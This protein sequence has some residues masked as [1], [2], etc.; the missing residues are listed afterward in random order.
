MSSTG[1]TTS[2]SHDFSAGGSTT[3]TGRE[4]PRNRA[5]SSIGRTVADSPMRCAGA[6]SRLS[7]CSRLNIRCAPRLVPAMAWISSMIT[8]SIPRSASRA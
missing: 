1:T 2:S 7:R 8:V 3:R 6:S 5:T 4:P